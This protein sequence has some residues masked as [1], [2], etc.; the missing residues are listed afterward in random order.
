MRNDNVV[1]FDINAIME[2]FRYYFYINIIDT[3]LLKGDDL[4]GFMSLNFCM[5]NTL[6]P[7]AYIH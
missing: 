3:N 1:F 6:I 7:M 2:K 4:N 5:V